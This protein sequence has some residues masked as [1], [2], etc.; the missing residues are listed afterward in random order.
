MKPNKEN[1][2]ITKA[3]I[4]SK[5]SDKNKTPS[6]SLNKSNSST[7]VTNSKL[8]KHDINLTPLRKGTHTKN[9]SLTITDNFEDKS[10]ISNITPVTTISNIN[11]TIAHE[12]Q[13]PGKSFHRYSTYGNYYTIENKKNKPYNKRIR[14]FLDAI[15]ESIDYS[16]FDPI[17][18]VFKNNPLTQECFTERLF[19]VINVR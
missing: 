5:K 14:S 13:E 19:E 17:M 4:D 8:S 6:K 1:K 12:G 9:K 16:K 10:I 7:K 18:E 2:E 15:Y 3:K 11:D